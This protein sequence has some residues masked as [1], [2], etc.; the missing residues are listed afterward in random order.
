MALAAFGYGKKTTKRLR[1]N[2]LSMSNVDISA[3][4]RYFEPKKG[5]YDLVFLDRWGNSHK[6]DDRLGFFDDMLWEAFYAVTKTPSYLNRQAY[7]FVI[8]D[9]RISLVSVPDAYT[10]ETDG[11]LSLGIALLHFNAVAEQWSGK[12]N[13][14]F[15]RDAAA[16][17]LPE[18]YRVVATCDL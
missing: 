17:E 13:W 11:K 18:G 2:I 14:R 8:H 16:L 3:K 6:L 9:G 4:R 15:G 7:G 1:L 10:T 5:I 12:L